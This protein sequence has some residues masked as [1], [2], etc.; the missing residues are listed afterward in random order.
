MA[1]PTE[2]LNEFQVNTGSAA[3]GTQSDPKIMG[4]ANG[5]FVVVWVESASGTIAVNPGTDMVAKIFDAEGNVVRDAYPLNASFFADDERDFDLTAT[6]DGF[7]IAFIDDSIASVNATAVRYERFDMAGDQI[8]VLSIDDENLAADFLR[9]PQL[10]ANLIAAND[11]VYVAYEDDVATNTD[12]NARVIDENGVPGT[13]FGSAQN[14]LDFDRLGDVAVLSNGNFVTAYEEDDFG[15]TGIEFVIRTA[16]GGAVNFSVAV[17]SDATDPSVSSLA[18]GGFVVTYVVNNDVLARAYSNTGVFQHAVTVAAGTNNQNEPT[19]VGLSDGGYVVFYDDD[20]SGSVIGRRFNADGSSDGL[21]FS[22]ETGSIGL[23]TLDISTTG[24]GRILFSWI[25]ANAEVFASI[26]DPR[27]STIDPGEYGAARANFLQSNVITTGLAGSTVLEGAKEDTVLGQG[28]ADTIFSSGSG[29]FF[30]GGG[31]DTVF[32]HAQTL[33]EDFELL[34]GGAGIDTLDTTSFAGN[35]TINLATGVTDYAGNPVGGNESFIN[36]ENTTTG[37]GNDSITGT[38]AANV[39]M[40]QSGNDT[41]VAGN[42]NDTVYAGAGDDVITSAALSGSDQ[43]FGG[44]GN[45][46]ITSSG[47]DTVF[48]EGGDDV[49]IAGIG[50]AETLDGGAGIDTL[51]TTLFTGDYE[52]DLA[53]GLTNLASENFTNFENVITG[54]GDD[55]VFGTLVANRLEA[56]AGNDR[57]LGLAG[58]DTLEGGLGQDTLNGGDGNDAITAGEGNDSVFAEAGDDLID[59][60]AGNDLLE[61]KDGN[62][63]IAGGLGNDT[64][65]GAEGADSILG[66]DGDDLAYGGNGDDSISGGAGADTLD[67]SSGNDIIDGS[68]GN[69]LIIGETGSDQL[70]GFNGNDT[71]RGGGGN[72]TISGESDDDLIF[73]ASG[74]DVMVG[75]S[76]N[77]TLDGGTQADSLSGDDGNDILRGEDGFDLLLGGLGNDI[78]A[79]G[80]GNDTLRG[81]AGQ[82]TLR[83]NAQSDTFDFD[84]AADSTFAAS[85]LIDG[86]EGVGT[87]GG[88]IIDV[89]GIDAN[90][91]L[92]GDQGFTFLGEQTTAGGLA[93]GAGGLWVEDVGGLT[94]LFGNTNSDATIEFAV[95][96][97]DGAGIVAADYLAD[98][99]IL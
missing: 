14:S 3:T 49:I 42:G 2:W 91:L 68:E 20:T 87:A 4:L 30:G 59:G 96:I 43:V 70:L 78:L 36:F 66:D 24:D 63:S 83:G 40:T 34:D 73:G 94:R 41:I 98:D 27:P 54:D 8:Q 46:T 33:P 22:V 1:T 9:N 65:R 67:G 47:L 10:A 11:D 38:A 44:D 31:N 17:A 72:D 21:P 32:A 95:D 90:T 12:V 50:G 13:E 26:W 25:G 85:D 53:T 5:G 69:D 88:D 92:A 81:D 97:N 28:G 84:F 61:G 39:I 16:S 37:A 58:D 93:F 19:V 71:L 86:I 82:D 56:G 89:G 99:F 60:G 23:T 57:V 51:N 62:D 35:Y 77:D 52:I 48:G 74:E 75:G 80:N 6:P 29:A 64:L 79:G 18:G 15:T 45:D 55:V 76:G 7:A